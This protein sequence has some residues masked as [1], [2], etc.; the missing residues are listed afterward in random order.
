[1][2]VESFLPVCGVLDILLGFQQLSGVTFLLLCHR[3]SSFLPASPWFRIS[4]KCGVTARRPKHFKRQL[5]GR[6]PRLNPAGAARKRGGA[7]E[8]MNALFALRERASAN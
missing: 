3:Y 4:I 8:T 2:I 6:W 1:M 5:F 7:G